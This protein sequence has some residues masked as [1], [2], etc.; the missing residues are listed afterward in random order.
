M[1]ERQGDEVLNLA[2]VWVKAQN[3]CWFRIKLGE[4]RR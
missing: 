1:K 3:S 4:N 2:M